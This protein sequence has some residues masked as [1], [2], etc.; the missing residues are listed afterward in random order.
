MRLAAD[1]GSANVPTDLWGDVVKLVQP[2]IYQPEW[3]PWLRIMM[4]AVLIFAGLLIWRRHR[5]A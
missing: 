3:T 4:M 2:A 1:G 5:R